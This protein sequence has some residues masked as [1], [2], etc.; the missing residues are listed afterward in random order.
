MGNVQYH[1]ALQLYEQLD[2]NGRLVWRTGA[3]PGFLLPSAYTI[4]WSGDLDYPDLVKGNAMYMGYTPG[5][6]I[7]P[8][9]SAGVCF[10]R[11]KAGEWGPSGAGVYLLSRILIGTVPADCNHLN[12]VANLTCTKTP[13]LW[14]FASD[15]RFGVKEGEDAN[16]DGGAVIEAT[17]GMRRIYRVRKVGTNVYLERLQ[18]VKAQADC[19]TPYPGIGSWKTGAQSGTATPLSQW[20]NVWTDDGDRSGWLVFKMGQSSGGNNGSDAFCERG[21]NNPPSSADISDF[22]STWSGTIT[23]RPGYIHT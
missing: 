2:D 23:V 8:Q 6:G 4:G 1:N 19:L 20:G 21:G 22:S 10:A 9:Q 18:S 17:I 14:F 13:D 5:G 7:N 3:S 16:L 11:A 12:I 15:F